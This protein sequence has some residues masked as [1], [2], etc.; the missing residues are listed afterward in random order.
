MMDGDALGPLTA[1][2]VLVLAIGWYTT[3]KQWKNEAIDRG[4]ALYCPISGDFA[5]KDECHD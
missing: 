5:W 2:L 3:N 4:Y 1:A